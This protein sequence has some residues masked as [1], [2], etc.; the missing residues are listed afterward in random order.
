MLVVHVRFWWCFVV[1][2]VVGG[3]LCWYVVILGGAGRGFYGVVVW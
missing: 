2:G 3:V 1:G